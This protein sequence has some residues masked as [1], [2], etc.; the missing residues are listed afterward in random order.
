MLASPTTFVFAESNSEKDIL[1]ALRRGNLFI[2]NSPDASRL[3]LS[4]KDCVQGDEIKFVPGMKVHLRAERLR[5]NMTLCVFNNEK[6]IYE[7]RIG[8]E[9]E[10]DEDI[11]ITEKGFELRPRA[12][13]IPSA[14]IQKGIFQHQNGSMETE[15]E[16][17]PV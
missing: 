4:Y 7:H 16:K 14:R 6:I 15:R 3:V 10:L 5:K 1:S 11:S 17:Y 13:N 2:T 12:D 9:S 8:G